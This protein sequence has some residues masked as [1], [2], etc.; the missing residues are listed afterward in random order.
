MKSLKLIIILLL[1]SLILVSC[2]IK[3]IDKPVDGIEEPNIE[4][5]E[6]QNNPENSEANSPIEERLTEL[7]LPLVCENVFNP[8]ELK[9]GDN[10]LGLKLVELRLREGTQEYPM[11]T[12]TAKFEGKVTLNGNFEY[13]DKNPEMGNDPYILFFPDEESNIK[14]PISHHDTRTKRTIWP[15]GQEE[16]IKHLEINPGDTLENQSIVIEDFTINYIPSDVYDSVVI[17]E[18]IKK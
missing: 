6:E 5:I 15:M 12:L 8:R 16:I 1:L 7:N 14:L 9:V 11:D 17:V 2:G 10:F 3:E 13:I 4:P 18:V